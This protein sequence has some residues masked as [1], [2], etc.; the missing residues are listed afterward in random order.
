MAAKKKACATC[1]PPKKEGE[2]EFGAK[3]K[4]KDEAAAAAMKAYNPRSISDN[5]EWGGF[6]KQN[7]D[8]T[9]SRTGLYKGEL[10]SVALPGAGR[11]GEPGSDVVG[12]WHTHGGPDP[13]YD[14]EIF[15]GM[16]GD[17]GVSSYYGITGYVA[18]PSGKMMSYNPATGSV[19]VMPGSAK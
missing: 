16:N 6:I 12:W 4:T 3:Y 11:P 10:A 17:M 13:A 18:T 14:G 9:F 19:T 8:G 15:S 1:T 5:R 2:E 7:A